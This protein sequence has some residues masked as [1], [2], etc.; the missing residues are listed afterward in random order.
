MD[1]YQ[2]NPVEVP[3]VDTKYR[4][5]KTAIPVPESIPLIKQIEKYEPRSM[6]GQPPVI[7]DRAE[8][9]QVYDIVIVGL[10]RQPDCPLRSHIL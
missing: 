10:A 6:Q 4:K 9:F 2:K 3:K 8:G 5:I 1:L 7:W